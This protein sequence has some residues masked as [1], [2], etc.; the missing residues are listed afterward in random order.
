MAGRAGARAA[1]R[2]RARP[3]RPPSADGRAPKCA[4][5]PSFA[6]TANDTC[7]GCY[8]TTRRRAGR[9]LLAKARRARRR[10]APPP[11]RSPRSRAAR[12]ALTRRAKRCKTLA[13]RPSPPRTPA[14]T[15]RTDRGETVEDWRT[16]AQVAL[17]LVAA[18]RSL[19]ES[20]WLGIAT[21]TTVGYGDHRATRRGGGE[22]DAA[23]NAAVIGIL[24]RDEARSRRAGRLAFSWQQAYAR[25]LAGAPSSSSCEAASS[26]VSATTT[27]AVATAARR[28]APASE[29]I[30]RALAPFRA[31]SA[32]AARAP[33]DGGET[34]TRQRVA[35]LLKNTTERARSPCRLGPMAGSSM[36][37]HV[38]HAREEDAPTRR[39][40]RRRAHR[41]RAHAEAAAARAASR[42]RRVARADCVLAAD[43]GSSSSRAVAATP[44]RRAGGS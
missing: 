34:A 41:R 17:V 27:R 37:A 15:T 25:A 4:D 7:D 14:R 19:G 9:R 31:Q 5:A 8:A 28:R 24:Q 44:T 1:R 12:N 32:L 29:R 38:Q 16:V 6:S 39:R 3:D 23:M 13:A 2:R 30:A 18:A 43:P 33:H 26:R 21:M 35:A 36:A 10:R 40:R 20:L 11:P 22:R 42:W